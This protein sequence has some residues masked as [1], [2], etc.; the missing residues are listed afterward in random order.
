MP[1]KLLLGKE[2]LEYYFRKLGGTMGCN[3]YLF[4]YLFTIH[5]MTPSQLSL[6][7]SERR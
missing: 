7:F 5:L 1:I 6:D 3:I 2:K 4:V